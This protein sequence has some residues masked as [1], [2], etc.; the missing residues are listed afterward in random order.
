MTTANPAQ[1]HSP[2][3][4]KLSLPPSPKDMFKITLSL[5]GV[6]LA[7]AAILGAIYLWTEPVKTKNLMEREKQTIVR[8]LELPAS[9]VVSEVLR[10]STPQ[11]EPVYLT[12]KLLIHF[13]EEGQVKSRLEVPAEIAKGEAEQKE[14]WALQTLNAKPLG[15]FY[16]GKDNSQVVGYVVEGETMGYKN[17]IRFF[18]AL[19]SNFTVRG[20]EILEQEEDPGLGGEISQK[21]FKNQFA[22]RS[23]E[24]TAQLTVTKDPYPDEWKKAVVE[25]GAL[26]YSQ[27]MPKNESQIPKQIY[28]ITGST[29]SSEAMTVGV[30][31]T[32]ANFQKRMTLIGGDL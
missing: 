6:C 28:S 11:L 19:T 5:T 1:Q 14:K 8:L 16:V 24:N 30:Q 26:P 18:V 4:Q 27:W 10:L 17:K 21:Y 32:L 31:K 3:Q 20:V 22:G 12:E 9:G 7:S 15:R 25:L 13:S 2:Q 23:A 29:I